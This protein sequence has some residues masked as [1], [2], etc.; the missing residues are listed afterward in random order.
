M[1]NPFTVLKRKKRSDAKRAVSNL[2]GRTPADF[3]IGEV[4]KMSPGCYTKNPYYIIISG[5]GIG[6]IETYIPG[7]HLLLIKYPS[8]TWEYQIPRMTFVGI[9]LGY[10]KYI[11]N[12]E[13]K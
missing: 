3:K 2:T 4:Y 1:K 8:L 6:F 13:L 12:Q 10:K 11:H 5:T 9:G 7:H